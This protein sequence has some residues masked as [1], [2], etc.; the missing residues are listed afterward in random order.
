MHERTMETN[1]GGGNDGGDLQSFVI[2]PKSVTD[3]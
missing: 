2:T 1:E 3:D